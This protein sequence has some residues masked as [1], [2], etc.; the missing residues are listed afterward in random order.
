MQKRV[1]D[2]IEGYPEGVTFVSPD[3]TYRSVKA[4]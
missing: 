2:Y 3:N 4:A 1:F